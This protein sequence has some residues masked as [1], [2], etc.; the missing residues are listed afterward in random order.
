MAEKKGTVM[1]LTS[2]NFNEWFIAVRALAKQCE[3]YDYINPMT[4]LVPLRKTRLP[5]VSDYAIQDLAL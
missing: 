4:D 3:C 2:N 1:A 5:D